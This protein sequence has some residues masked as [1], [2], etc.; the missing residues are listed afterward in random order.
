[1]TMKNYIPCNLIIF[2]VSAK[3]AGGKS[4]KS[5]SVR[6]FAPVGNDKGEA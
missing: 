4:R 6:G 1:M 5:P 3:S 2:A